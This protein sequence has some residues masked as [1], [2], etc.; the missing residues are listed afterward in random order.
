MPFCS[1]SAIP[2]ITPPRASNPATTSG[3]N[4][5]NGASVCIGASKL[6]APAFEGLERRSAPCAERAQLLRAHDEAYVAKVFATVPGEGEAFIAPDT[7]V[8]PGSLK[9][10]MR[11]AGAVCA[12]VDAVAAGEADNAFCAVR[13]PGHHAA[14]GNTMGF[15]VFNN[16]AVGAE[17][18]RQARGFRRVAVVDFDVHHGN[19]TEAIFRTNPDV[20]VASIHQSL[21]FP[22]TG[23]SSETGVGNI[24][25][26][27]VARRIRA[28]EFRR[29]F[30]Q[31]LLPPLRAFDPDFL[32]ISAGFDAHIRDPLGDQRLMTADF[33]WLTEA[34]LRVAEEHCGGRLVSVMEGGYNP[35][36]L[37]DACQ[38]HVGALMRGRA[39]A[40]A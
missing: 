26:V 27:P 29:A 38:A 28:E 24:V 36:A 8:S 2:A 13:P 35:A 40:A 14:A 37:A 9:A 4:S 19:G 20:M 6:S 1:R 25:N 16:V 7:M 12:A 30:E 32:F 34:L 17:H 39:A 22:N 10:A 23:D 15:C 3:S 33:A 31:K 18:A 5:N 11:A 21:I